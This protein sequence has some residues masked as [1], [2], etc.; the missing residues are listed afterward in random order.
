MDASKKKSNG[1]LCY[2]EYWIFLLGFSVFRCLSLKAAYRLARRIST[3]IFLLD[4]KHRTRSIQHLLH[5]GVAKTP[6][7]ARKIALESFHNSGKTFVEIVKIDQCINDSNYMEKLSLEISDPEA[8][9]ILDGSP[10]QVIVATAHLG[11]WE[12]AG[13]AYCWRGKTRMTS[14]MRPLNNSKIGD[15]IYNHRTNDR[16]TT[17]SRERGVRPLLEALKKGETLAIVSDQHASST[18]GVETTFF[19]HPVRTHATPALLHLKTGVPIWPCFL[20][21][22]D[23]DFHFAFESDGLIIYKPTGDKHADVIAITQT[24]N[25]AIEKSVRRH[26]EQWLWAH[27]R[28]LDI[29]RNHSHSEE[30]HTT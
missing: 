15:Y 20:I 6:E 25:D 26:P 10:R 24:I 23:E 19:G 5:S 29:N 11:N 2:L 17:V 4:S 27:R 16:H 18:E 7:E 1:I 13:S 28:W 30:I 3:L 14:I 12:L 9:K 22:K 21:R 8:R